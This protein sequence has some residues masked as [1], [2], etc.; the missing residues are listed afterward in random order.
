MKVSAGRVLRKFFWDSYD[1]LGVMILGNLLWFGLCLPIVTAPASTA[2]LFSLTNHIAAGKKVSIKDFWDGFRKYFLRSV[3]LTLIYL[4]LLVMVE[5]NIFLYRHL[6][7]AGRV[8]FAFMGAVNLWLL[9]L[10]ALIEIYSLP[11]IVKQDIGL[12]KA[13][14]RSALLALDNPFFTIVISIQILAIVFLSVLSGVGM[15]LL[16]MSLVSLL[17]SRALRELFGKYEE[18][19]EEEKEEV[20]SL[21]KIFRPWE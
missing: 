16:L 14:K 4:L 20:R 1:N 5:S 21:K 3:S 18:G 19:K 11:L 6:N 13:L 2:A 7:Q 12:K 17:L 8:V 10:F 9:L 15:V